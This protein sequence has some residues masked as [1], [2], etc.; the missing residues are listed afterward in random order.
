M[1]AN[2]VVGAFRRAC[3]ELDVTV[4]EGLEQLK[5]LGSREVR[6]KGGGAWLRIPAP[7]AGS[8]PLLKPLDVHFREFKAAVQE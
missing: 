4:K 7:R 3:A 5:A 1:L 6:T 8:R 2:L